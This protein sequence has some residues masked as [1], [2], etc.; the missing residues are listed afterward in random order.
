MLLVGSYGANASWLFRRAWA[1]D[2]ELFSSQY[3]SSDW[4]TAL[5]VFPNTKISYLPEKLYFYRMHK[6]QITRTDPEK[7]HT[8]LETWSRLNEQL[9]LPKLSQHEISVLTLPKFTKVEK[10]SSENIVDWSIEFRKLIPVNSGSEQLLRRRL[11]ILKSRHPFE[12]K[13]NFDLPILTRMLSEF[14]WNFT[15][16]RI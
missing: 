13:A 11:A 5:R 10:R 12:F 2:H 4:T 16:P 1:K 3:D 9:N 6:N 15:K 8:L 14:A 7:H